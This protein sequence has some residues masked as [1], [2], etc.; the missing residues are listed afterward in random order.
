MSTENGFVQTSI[1]KLD[2]EKSSAAAELYRM[3]VREIAMR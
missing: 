1:N 3:P 2:A